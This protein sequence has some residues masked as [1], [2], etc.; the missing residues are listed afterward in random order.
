MLRF[1]ICSTI[2]KTTPAQLH[3]LTL[4]PLQPDDWHYMIKFAIEQ[5]EMQ[6]AREKED[7]EMINAERMRALTSKADDLGDLTSG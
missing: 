2:I 1:V 4:A 5:A 7:E 6:H 3:L